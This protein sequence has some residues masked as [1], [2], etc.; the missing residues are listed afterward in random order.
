MLDGQHAGDSAR[1]RWIAETEPQGNLCLA[2]RLPGLN[3]RSEHVDCFYPSF[4]LLFR[5]TPAVIAGI[6]IRFSR[7]LTSEKAE[8]QR[9]SNNAADAVS[10]T[11]VEKTVLAR[12]LIDKIKVNLNDWRAETR[13]HFQCVFG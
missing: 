1:Y 3:R 4:A 6:E 11:G 13:D 7:V 10:G 5:P 8:A 2:L 9:R 12:A